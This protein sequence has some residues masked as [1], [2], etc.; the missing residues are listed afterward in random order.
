MR[1]INGWGLAMLWGMA[2]ITLIASIIHPTAW[3]ASGLFCTLI[4]TI[5]W[6]YSRG[7][8]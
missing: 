2:P 3:G 8:K 4:L 1:T 5:W 6:G 7:R